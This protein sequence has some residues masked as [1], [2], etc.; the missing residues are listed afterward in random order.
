MHQAHNC[1]LHN[2]DFFSCT[3]FNNPFEIK[4]I[5]HEIVGRYANNDELEKIRKEVAKA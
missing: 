2:R 3:F 4:T 1:T 5:Q